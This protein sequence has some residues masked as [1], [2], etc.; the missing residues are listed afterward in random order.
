MTLAILILAAGRS[1]RMAGADKLLE[2][3]RGAALMRDRAEA[4]L[5]TGYPVFVTLPEADT[6]RE[7]ALKGLHLERVPSPNA[8]HGMAGSLRDG[9][10]ALPEGTDGV[11]VVLADMPDTTS[12]DMALILNS[13]VPD[14]ILRGASGPIAGHPVLFPAMFFDDL[15]LLEGDSGARA[16]IN[17]AARVRLVPLP[18][19][20]ALCDLDTPEDWAAWR[21]MD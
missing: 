10:A 20:H 1:S 13:F 14:T 18:D 16:V 8:A 21:E 2:P 12:A 15:Q 5:E 19:R 11:L 7:T 9:I 3:V 4:A 17:K 6:A